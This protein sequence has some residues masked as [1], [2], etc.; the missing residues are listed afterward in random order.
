MR[1]YAV[2]WVHPD[3]KLS[4]RVDTQGHTNP[5]W[6]DKFV[7]R[8]D[9][10]FLYNDTSAIMIEIYAL[11]W[12]KDIHVGTI[13]VLVGNLIPPPSGDRAPLGMRFVALQVRR[14]SGRPQ[15]ILNIGFTVLDSSMR[16]MPLYT[17]N[18]SAVGYQHLMGETDN[19]NDSHNHLSPRVVAAGGGGGKPQ[20]RR[21]KSDTSSILATE[22]V[23]RHQRNSINKERANS[24]ISGSEVSEHKVKK[25]NKKKKKKKSSSKASSIISSVSGK[26]TGSVLSDA[27]VPW[28]VKNGKTSSTPSETH[29]DQPPPPPPFNDDEHHHHHDDDNNNNN[30]HENEV[31]D[32]DDD[33][34]DNGNDTD[35]NTS[36]EAATTDNEMNEKH[37]IA[38]EVRVTPRRHY[39]PS[40]KVAPAE[41]RNSSMPKFMKSPAMPEYKNIPKPHY[42]QSPMP[43]YK[44]SPKPQFHK[45]PMPAYMNSPKPQ[46][47]KSPMPE[48]MNSPKPQF[49][50]SPMPQYMNSPKPQFH[51]SPMPEYKSTPKPQFHKSPMPEYKNSPKPNFMRSSAMPE[52]MNSP[53]PQFKNSPMPEFKNSPMPQFRNSPMPEY[54]NSPMHPV[55]N[56]PMPQFRNSPMPEYNNSPMHPVRN[57]PMPQFR[58]SPMPQFRNSPAVASHFR[59]SPAVT[60]FNPAM[61][62]GGSQRGT[63]MHP[64]GK[65]NGAM[66]Y[67]TPMR[68]NLAN[69]RPV[70][71][72]ESELGPSP[73]EVAAAMARKPVIDED[74]STVGGWSLDESVEG[75]ESKLD[76]WRTELPPVIDQ[77]ELSSFPTTTSTKTSRHSRRNTDGGSGKG[78]F[79]CFSTICGL[80]CSIVCG[81]DPK[82][83]AK[84]KKN[85]N[86]SSSSAD[87]ATTGTSLL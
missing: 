36:S 57:S 16:S 34:D 77:G 25:S 73:S 68:S 11:H 40:P 75:L 58:N 65:M 82:D 46:F 12:F 78:L 84:A 48:Y 76:R 23:M 66:E 59:N 86:R 53:K 69:M 33:D 62:F 32:D 55:R 37:N 3:R 44:N 17:H 63:P 61:G 39:P 7:F 71:M 42:K 6:N 80:E 85:R 83:K 49:H 54:N 81:G 18:A 52:Y 19:Y 24:A 67:A 56:S 31:D 60:K 9:E 74:T 22:A 29:V 14:P 5:T 72:T 10:N 51:Q 4:T 70:M 45:S 21:T 20:L 2:A 35:V 38:Y 87:D 26:F 27:V 1:T 64:L 41:F 28:K 50:K 79:S 30:N 8:V 15:G 13:R 43:E 47:H